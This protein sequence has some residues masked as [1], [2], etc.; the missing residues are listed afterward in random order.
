MLLLTNIAFLA[1]RPVN[2]HPTQG[3]K[4]KENMEPKPGVTSLSSTCGELFRI[5]LYL[6]YAGV[7]SEEC[8]SFQ[9]DGESV[10]LRNLTVG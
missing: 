3:K 8:R 4:G 2:F 6:K 1:V 10:V 9:D 7:W 5:C